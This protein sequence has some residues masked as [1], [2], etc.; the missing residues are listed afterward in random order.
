MT[1][2]ETGDLPGTRA[3]RWTTRAIRAQGAS[4]PGR[5]LAVV[6][7]LLALCWLVSYALG[8]AGRVPPHWF[9][10]PVL[11]AATRF[12]LPGAAATAV[13]AGLVAGPL[14][15]LDVAAGTPQHLLDWT[16]RLGF[17]LGIGLVMG[18]II[19][20]LKSSLERE[21]AFALE[22]RDLAVQHGEQRTRAIIETANE[23]VV[24]MDASGSVTDWNRAAEA[25]FGWSREEA[26]G[27]LLADTVIPER[28]RKDHRKGLERFIT[29]GEALLLNRR[30]EIEALHREGHEFPVELTISALREGGSVSFIA[31]VHDITERKRAEE[32][33]R[34]SEAALREVM[35][36]RYGTLV[37]Q[38]PA[39][40]Y[41]ADFGERGVWR[42]VSPQIEGMLGFSPERWMS[43][44]DLWWKQMHPD[45]RARAIA[46]EARSRE[47]GEPL[48]SE[49][50]MLARDG[51]IFWF[52]DQAAV[53]L[54]G[55]GRPL[56]LQGVMYDIT[57]QK[58]AEQEIR[59][60]NADLERRVAD[61]T[62]ELDTA[63][64][65]LIER[66][67]RLDESRVEAERANQAKSE[68]LS[69]MSHE[70]RT[71]LNAILGFGQL[72]EMDDLSDEQRDAVRQILRGGR[73]LLDLINEVLDIARIEAGRMHLSLE[74]VGA[75][76]IVHDGLALVR[77]LA[78]ERDVRIEVGP[79]ADGDPYVVADRQRLQQTLLNLLSNAVKYNRDAGAVR[80][81]T[82]W[83]G[84]ERLCIDVSDDGVG[85]AP[86]K[87]QRL[88]VPFER[89]G[90]EHS[91]VEGTGLGLALSR[92]LVEVMG[93]D[94]RV[95]STLGRGSTFTVELSVAAAPDQASDEEGVEPPDRR[96]TTGG[97][98]T[99]LCIEDNPANLNV[100]E[101]IMARLPGVTLVTAM[102]G[103]LG[104]DLA[105]TH[106]PDVILLDVGLPD[107]PGLEVLRRLREDPSTSA[108]P[109]VVISADAS[110]HQ[111]ERFLAAGARDYVTK[112]LD[113]KK[114]NALLDDVLLEH[115]ARQESEAGS[116]GPSETAKR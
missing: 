4:S 45:D 44:P 53:V 46:D 50:R 66:E 12:G 59:D 15:P 63:N 110:E 30:I 37:E 32:A 83:V 41:E 104:V 43:E 112:P 116:G 82:R 107:M 13:V 55:D 105:R 97:S 56:F 70:L 28:Y 85:I 24:G 88:F 101:R 10:V 62:S 71:P 1:D 25:T 54:A 87:L 91:G 17:F 108:I 48:H 79:L 7:V 96:V 51:R 64:R 74:P 89:L 57:N 49:Y 73:H 31:F 40:V 29:T 99:V 6:A 115:K 60:M 72:L 90:A 69:R 84:D 11:V 98:R 92:H 100:I 61:R 81:S 42:Y 78:E 14:L 27:R 3:H 114:L 113:V 2:P 77:L 26:V 68:F 94:L 86:E 18:A 93:G 16:A 52:R 76:T 95:E 34:E 19:V 21:I 65:E 67:R 109:V 75:N 8:G 36:A 22:G 20:R 106:R 9:Y 38:L 58:R 23:A 80:I 102:Q 47:T 103:G 5:G 39:I 33:L 35:E 111:V